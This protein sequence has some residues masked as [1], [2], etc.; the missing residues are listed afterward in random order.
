MILPRRRVHE[1]A[2]GWQLASVLCSANSART[3]RFSRILGKSDGSKTQ[4]LATIPRYVCANPAC[5]SADKRP[6]PTLIP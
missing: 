2:E 3:R 1:V 4:P 5:W 6:S